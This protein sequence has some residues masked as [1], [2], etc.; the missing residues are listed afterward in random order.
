VEQGVVDLGEEVRKMGLRRR[1]GAPRALR[2]TF[3]YEGEE[4]RLQNLR[5][6]EMIAPPGDELSGSEQ[7]FWIEVRDEK[8][9]T[10]HRLV[11]EDPLSRD[12]E[13]FSPDPEHSVY[14]VPV[15]K[16]SGLFVVVV[17]DLEGA[18]HVALMSSGAPSAAAREVSPEVA[19]RAPAGPA[20]EFARFPLRADHEGGES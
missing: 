16:P 4:V 8:D 14:R 15:E 19:S 20:A 5:P 3:A 1:D 6:V 9:D 11:M 7:G 12:V 2:L 18:D 17:P 13:V 10:L